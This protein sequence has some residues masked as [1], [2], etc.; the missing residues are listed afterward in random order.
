MSSYKIENFKKEMFTPL[1]TIN[2]TPSGLA[3]QC[4]RSTLPVYEL[5]QA[6]LKEGRP[7]SNLHGCK[8]IGFAEQMCKPHHVDYSN[9]LLKQLKKEIPD[10]NSC[11][12]DFDKYKECYLSSI[13]YYIKQN[14]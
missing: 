4:S 7:D 3:V 5:Y 8:M 14:R 2:R 13:E 1:N 10:H 9:G 6:P 11:K 12:D